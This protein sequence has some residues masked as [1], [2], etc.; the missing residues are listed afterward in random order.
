MRKTYIFAVFFSLFL[1]ACGDP[2]SLDGVDSKITKAEV[3]QLNGKDVLVLEYRLKNLWDDASAVSYSMMNLD[4]ITKW[5]VDHK[6]EQGW[7]DVRWIVMAVYI[8]V[9]DNYGNSETEL[10][11]NYS[12]KV[13]ELEKINWANATSYTVL[14]LGKFVPETTLGRKAVKAWCVD[15]N[16]EWANHA[17]AR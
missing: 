10:A 3:V 13:S 5:V 14:N 17:C 15:K 8:P 7:Q 16:R 2:S 11:L 4:K 12:F 1:T 6:A 9:I